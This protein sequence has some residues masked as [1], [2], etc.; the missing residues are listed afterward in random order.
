LHEPLLNGGSSARAGTRGDLKRFSAMAFF[1]ASGARDQ[2]GL[3]LTAPDAS[4]RR[5]IEAAR[6]RAA[7]EAVTQF[8]GL[9]GPAAAR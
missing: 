2:S 1:P 5:A 4:R 7:Q 6:T 3:I 8:F 9:S